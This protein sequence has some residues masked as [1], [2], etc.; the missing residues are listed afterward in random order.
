[1]NRLIPGIKTPVFL[2]LAILL[3][4][5]S[6]TPKV[7]TDYNPEYDFGNINSYYL[8]DHNVASG[9][10][11]TSLVDQRV[12]RAIASEMSKRGIK[13]ADE[14]QAGI[15]VNFYIVTRDKTR[16]TSY[17]T[18]YGY[19]GYGYG[20][21]SPYYGG[22][23]VDVHQYTEGTL[24]LDLVDPKSKKTVWRGQSSAIVKDRPAQE[25]EAMAKA[26]V[27]ALFQHMPPPLGTDGK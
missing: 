9:A 4:A 8:V 24:L 11:D 12:S 7:S 1:M 20:I 27:Q 10:A 18:A 23:Q 22:N 5:C 17:N 26:Y 15:I 16:V 6:G 3:S 19:R 14:Q 2:A 21:A 13:P 25:R